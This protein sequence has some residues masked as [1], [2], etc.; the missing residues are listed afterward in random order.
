[1]KKLLIIS[2]VFLFGGFALAQNE[3]AV[4]NENSVLVNAPEFSVVRN[5]QNTFTISSRG[6]YL[7]KD[8]LGMI[9]ATTGSIPYYSALITD[10]IPN[11]H[12]NDMK[13]VDNYAF[14][15]GYVDVPGSHSH[16]VLGY[17]NL[18]DFYAYNTLSIKLHVYDT[19]RN[20]SKMVAYYDI[21]GYKVVA[22]G[23]C[24]VPVSGGYYMYPSCIVEDYIL[25]SITF[26]YLRYVQF[27]P[28]G[29]PRE[30]LT[31][32]ILMDNLIVFVG[33]LYKVS[34]L[35]Y[36]YNI[37]CLRTANRH[38]VLN[39]L[40]NCN[41]Y[42]TG[43]D[44]VSGRVHA[45]RL[46]VGMFAV[47]YVFRDEPSGVFFTRIRT[48]DLSTLNVVYSQEF[49][50]Y[51]KDEPIDMAYD[52]QN[53]ILTI[54]HPMPFSY[55]DSY[56]QSYFVQ[57]N[58]NAITPYSASVLSPKERLFSS[59]DMFSDVYYVSTGENHWYY[60]HTTAPEPNANNC[61]VLKKIDVKITPNPV[62]SIDLGWNF[63]SSSLVSIETRS[64]LVN[65][66]TID[67]QCDDN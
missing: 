64:V 18:N 48:F 11:L 6:K 47:S 49:P 39:T 8:S 19:I 46:K 20:F 29:Y 34:I 12:I 33:Y 52:L 59:L 31:D 50:T 1:M 26:N 53:G 10:S 44:E 9:S 27:T 41:L 55:I 5:W 7:V 16:G 57:I 65:T 45:A 22:I 38:D 2:I 15:C 32:L 3:S 67:L 66:T 62:K 60:Q 42:D 56:L 35:S 37:L 24:I 36:P 28:Y 58:P 23:T 13:F 21:T 51:Q 43:V 54:L 61:P 40:S 30:H 17:F 63:L 14:I 25:S 4:G